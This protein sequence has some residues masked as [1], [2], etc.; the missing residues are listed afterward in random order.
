[1][2]AVAQGCFVGSELH[3]QV[4]EMEILVAHSFVVRFSVSFAICQPGFED[5]QQRSS[6][7][8]V[9]LNVCMSEHKHAHSCICIQKLLE[10]TDRLFYKSF[11]QLL[12][13]LTA[14]PWDCCGS[15]FPR[16]IAKPDVRWPLALF[17]ICCNKVVL[18]GFFQLQSSEYPHSGTRKSS[19]FCSNDAKTVKQW[20]RT[21][22]EILNPLLQPQGLG[23]V[24]L[25]YYA[26]RE[27]ESTDMKGWNKCSAVFHA[28]EVEAPLISIEKQSL[29]NL[30]TKIRGFSLEEFGFFVASH[31]SDKI[32]LLLL[33][34]FYPFFFIYNNQYYY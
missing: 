20:F 13:I 32:D 10:E 16:V 9:R 5:G 14:C 4:G 27:I 2:Q 34:I 26:N 23:P 1:M 28:L 25:R 3:V 17:A 31:L 6:G 8:K 7:T 19:V 11:V 24:S 22:A 18:E 33:S 29:Y 12:M 30:F 15:T 21:G